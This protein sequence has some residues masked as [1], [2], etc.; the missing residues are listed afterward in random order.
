MCHG[1][2]EFLNKYILSQYVSFF[3]YFQDV[4]LSTDLSVDGLAALDQEKTFLCASEVEYARPLR[5]V[6]SRGEWNVIV[7]DI[8]ASYDRLT[9]TA[10]IERCR[11]HGEPCRHLPGVSL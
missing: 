4:L 7:N 3:S 9:Q 8:P 2:K 1:F 10:R 11:G 5:A 6:N